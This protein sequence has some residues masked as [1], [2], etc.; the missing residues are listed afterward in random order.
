MVAILRH[1]LLD[2]RLVF[3][4]TVLYAL[5]TTGVAGAY[6]ALVAVLDTAGE[7]VVS[8]RPP[9]HLHTYPLRH[10]KQDVGEL[11][12]G[13]RPGESRLG[14]AD[15]AILRLLAAPLPAAVEAAA[16]RREWD[17]HPCA[18]APPNSADP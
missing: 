8:G 18:N 11:V 5:L 10:G 14:G 3:S 7:V 6:M 13:L 16:F 15:H 4:R 9:H 17:C 12:V 2:I 1:Q